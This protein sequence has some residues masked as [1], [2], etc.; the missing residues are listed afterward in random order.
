[1]NHSAAF[2]LEVAHH[3]PHYKRHRKMLKMFTPGV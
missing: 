2:W 1:M 3:D